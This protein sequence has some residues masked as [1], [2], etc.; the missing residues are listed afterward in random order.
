MAQD[1][2]RRLSPVVGLIGEQLPAALFPTT[3]EGF[4][5]SALLH[6]RPETVRPTAFQTR[7]R[8]QILFH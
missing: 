1:R 7:D 8:T 4:L 5:P 3:I 6:A 2:L